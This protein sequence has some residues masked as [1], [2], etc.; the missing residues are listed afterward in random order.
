MDSDLCT[1]TAGTFLYDVEE[2][3]P[4]LLKPL[5]GSEDAPASLK[6]PGTSFER[7][8]LGGKGERGEGGDDDGGADGNGGG[9]G[10]W[11]W[12]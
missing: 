6:Q 3:R 12:W 4:R 5:Q 9:G 8:N 2:G 1:V 11:W 7:Q 10:W